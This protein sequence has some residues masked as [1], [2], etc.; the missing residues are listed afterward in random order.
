[1]AAVEPGRA[2]NWRISVEWGDSGEGVYSHGTITAGSEIVTE[3]QVREYVANEIG[4][5]RPGETVTIRHWEMVS[6]ESGG[7]R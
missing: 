3:E 5:E 7:A 6:A 1:M 2:Y 4:K